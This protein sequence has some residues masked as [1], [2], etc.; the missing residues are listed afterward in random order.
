MRDAVQ[1]VLATDRYGEP[2]SPAAG[3]VINIRETG[4]IHHMRAMILAAGLGTRLRPL[5][6]VRPKALV[7]VMGV[8]VLEYWVRRLHS[9]G[10]ESAAVNA[11]HLHEELSASVRGKA[12]PIPLHVSV[13]RTL[14]GTGGGIRNALDFFCGEPFAVVNADIVCRVDLED[15]FLRHLDSG[16]P[17]SLL[18]HDCPPFNNVATD[19]D[20]LIL[21]FGIEAVRLKERRPDVQLLAFTGIHFMNP[22]ILAGLS[23]GK[24]VEILDVYRELIRANHPPRALFSDDLYWREMGSIDSYRALHADLCE[25]DEG[26]LSPLK[27]GTKILAGP[28]AIVSPDAV[29]RGFVNLGEDSRIMAGAE[30]ENTILWDRVRIEPGSVLSNCIVADGATVEGVHQNEILIQDGFR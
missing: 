6:Y 23:Q 20:G 4:N 17:A 10:F 19:K 22:A 21:G 26:F 13:E 29:L 27:T 8:P 28:G 11:F 7:P 30:L 25:M 16:A 18:L 5:T 24:P 15:L 3:D 12:W 14:L 2:F 9:S 1:P